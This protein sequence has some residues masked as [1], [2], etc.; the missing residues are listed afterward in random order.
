M[1][2]VWNDKDRRL[3]MPNTV[4]ETESLGAKECLVK[5]VTR[6]LIGGG[7]GCLFIYSCSAR[8]IL[9]E[10]ELISQEIRRA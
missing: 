5:D 6:T 3:K 9:F 8:R 1:S 4:Y 10:F 2:M 7:G